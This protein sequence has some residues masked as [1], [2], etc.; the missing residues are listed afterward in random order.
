[1]Y[2]KFIPNNSNEIHNERY[3]NKLYLIN[4]DIELKKNLLQSFIQKMT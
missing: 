2:A 3:F 4:Q 1:M